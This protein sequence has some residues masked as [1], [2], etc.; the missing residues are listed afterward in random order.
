M[1][2]DDVIYRYRL[3]TLA[4]AR[5]ICSVRAACRAMGIHHSTYY[6]WK[7]RADSYGLQILRL[8]E[9]RSPQ[10]P[11][12][13]SPLYEHRILAFSIGH[14]GFGPLRIAAELGRPK[15]GGLQ[16][17]SSDVYRVLRRNGLKTPAPG[18]SPW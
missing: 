18:A 17:S 1:T 16:V 5:E 11:N 15:W 6:R 10:M 3:R 9:R 13:L 14:P 2:P 4:L 12:S 8:R 7:S